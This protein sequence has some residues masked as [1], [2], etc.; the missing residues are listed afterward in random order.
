MA[1][2]TIAA[3]AMI[4]SS[5]HTHT[6]RQTHFRP[7]DKQRKLLYVD[8]LFQS[9]WR[10]MK[11]NEVTFYKLRRGGVRGGEKTRDKHTHTHFTN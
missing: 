2:A 7:T 3:A 10:K 9:A 5:K 8:V 4:I 6:H 11:K 1:A